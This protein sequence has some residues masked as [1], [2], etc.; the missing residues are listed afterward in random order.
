MRRA[1]GSVAEGTAVS[2][3]HLVRPATLG[4]VPD[5]CASFKRWRKRQGHPMPMKG[6]DTDPRR[7]KFRV[8]ICLDKEHVNVGQRKLV[9]VLFHLSGSSKAGDAQG[10]SK[11]HNYDQAQQRGFVRRARRGLALGARLDARIA[12]QWL[13]AAL[14]R[15]AGA[16]VARLL[17]TIISGRSAQA[18]VMAVRALVR[19]RV[20]VARRCLLR[21][22]GA[23]HDAA[24]GA[25]TQGQIRHRSRRRVRSRR[26]RRVGGARP[27]EGLKLLSVPVPAHVLRCAD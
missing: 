24:T 1:A 22:D 11:N 23:S 17:F 8:A 10:G 25:T 4:L 27:G 19:Q 20:G 2:R 6:T 16:A 9:T 15:P 14:E 5:G 12:A 3:A 26:H 21:R 7:A 18:F 13:Q